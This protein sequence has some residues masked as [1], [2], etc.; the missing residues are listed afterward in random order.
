MH[1]P[2]SFEDR[3]TCTM[4][5]TEFNNK[6]IKAGGDEYVI[7]IRYADSPE[8]KTLKQQVSSA[9]AFRSQ[10][11]VSP[12]TQQSSLTYTLQE[13]LAATQQI[14]SINEF[15]AALSNPTDQTYVSCAYVC[16][17]NDH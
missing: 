11:D 9:R 1:I 7:N 17:T 2:C 15:E 12:T 10:G 5:V 3:A 14:T 16:F 13:Y 4:V 8:Q 6:A